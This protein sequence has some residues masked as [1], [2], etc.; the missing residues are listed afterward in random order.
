MRQLVIENVGSITRTGPSS[1]GVTVIPAHVCGL[2]GYGHPDDTCPGCD[3]SKQLWQ[4]RD[5][6][7]WRDA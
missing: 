3:A 5:E 4:R 7:D 6:L 2:T 1:W